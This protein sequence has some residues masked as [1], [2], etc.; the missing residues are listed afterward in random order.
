MPLRHYT[1]LGIPRKK[2]RHSDAQCARD[3]AGPRRA[4][5][6]GPHRTL[7]DASPALANLPSHVRAAVFAA[8]DGENGE[9][10][11][12]LIMWERRRGVLI[13]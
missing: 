6:C 10:A 4:F 8:F 3:A 12:A 2:S 5:A 9:I 7:Q 1:S 13:M 11:G